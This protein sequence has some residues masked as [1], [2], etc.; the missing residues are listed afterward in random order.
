MS[1]LAAPG[2]LAATG[3]VIHVFATALHVAARLGTLV[4][5]LRLSQR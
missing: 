4:R 2:F 5:V 1:V 3:H